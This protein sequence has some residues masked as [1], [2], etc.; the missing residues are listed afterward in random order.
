MEAYKGLKVVEGGF[1]S[2]KAI[3]LDLRP[4]HHYPFYVANTR[5]IN[6]AGTT[7]KV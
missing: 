5:V 6:R 3:D 4:V 7:L 2:L 1:R